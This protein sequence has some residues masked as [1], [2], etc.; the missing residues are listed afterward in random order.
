MDAKITLEKSSGTTVAVRVQVTPEMLRLA[1]HGAK[2]CGATPD[3]TLLWAF[4]EGIASFDSFIND[5]S[6]SDAGPEPHEEIPCVMV[7]TDGRAMPAAS[8]PPDGFRAHGQRD[9]NALAGW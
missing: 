3:Q 1:Q 4:R 6:L 7:N 9:H 8:A 5:G 2:M